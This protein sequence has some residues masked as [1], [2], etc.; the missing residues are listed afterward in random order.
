MAAPVYSIS[1]YR[2][3][4]LVGAHVLTVPAG[5]RYIVRDIN[6]VNASGT[7]PN[8]FAFGLNPDPFFVFWQWSTAGAP[9]G[10]QWQGRLV[11]DPGEEMVVFGGSGG[12]DVYVGGYQL[13]LP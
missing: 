7:F 9:L 8:T 1:M 12:V 11:F 13:T 4:G 5:L 2:Q 10:F 6:V 3:A